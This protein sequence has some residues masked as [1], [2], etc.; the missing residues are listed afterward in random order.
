MLNNDCFLIHRCFTSAKHQHTAMTITLWFRTIWVSSVG[1]KR[2][3]SVNCWRRFCGHHMAGAATHVA[4]VS[5]NSQLRRFRRRGDF[6]RLT[7]RDQKPLSAHKGFI[8]PVPQQPGPFALF[9]ALRDECALSGNKR[10]RHFV[11]LLISLYVA[12]LKMPSICSFARLLS[13]LCLS[14][15]SVPYSCFPE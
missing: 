8:A 13:A 2:R 1:C 11:R 14:A 3:F 15:L 10:A 5:R 7:A 12:V 4:S 9:C 6:A